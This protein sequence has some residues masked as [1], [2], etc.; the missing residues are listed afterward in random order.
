MPTVLIGGGSGLIGTRLSQLLQE[1]GYD[2]IHLSRRQR[3]NA[4]Y[5]TYQWDAEGGTIE[6]EAVQAADY[7]INLAGAGIADKPWTKARK[8]LIISS[9]VK[10]ARLFKEAFERTGHQPKAYISSSAIGYYGDRGETLMTEEA[11]AGSGFL[12]ES[13]IAWES[14]IQEVAQTGVRTVGIRIGIVMST[15]G[16]ALEKMLI[17]F[18]FYTGTYFGDGQQW[19]SWVHIDDICRLFIHAME[20]ESMNGFYNGVAPNPVRN[21]TLVEQ[22]KNAMNS[23]AI[24][25]PAPAFALRL[26]MGEMADAILDST[27]VS[28]EKTQSTGFNFQFPEIDKA[29]GDLL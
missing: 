20:N 18:R 22:I 9:R 19:Y 14:A 13:T 15:Q 4:P 21:K 8:A 24:L 28:A 2:P 16:G 5:P 7:V 17:P 3:P 29:L 6:E 25:V 27:K 1:K 23:P 26:A 10:T 12:S 11:E